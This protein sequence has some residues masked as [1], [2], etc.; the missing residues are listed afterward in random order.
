MKKDTSRA[1]FEVFRRP[2]DTEKPRSWLAKRSSTRGGKSEEAARPVESG[3]RAREVA[4]PRGR[5]TLALSREALVILMFAIVVVLVASHVWGYRRGLARTDVAGGQVAVGT[6]T[7]LADD[8][9]DRRIASRRPEPTDVEIRTLS[10][11]ATA[12][13]QLELPFYTLRIISGI[14]LESARRIREELLA[15]GYDAFIYQDRR[16]SGFTVNVGRYTTNSAPELGQLKLRF[17]AVYRDCYAMPLDARG[18][19]IP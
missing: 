12:R 7:R 11:D 16:Y 8:S 9:A 1:F 5:L 3:A 10:L 14:Q 18:K 2:D 17:L 15:K 4:S 13:R 19:I 6:G